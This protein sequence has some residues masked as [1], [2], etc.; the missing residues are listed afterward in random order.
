ML[1]KSKSFLLLVIALAALGADQKP[2]ELKPGFNF[3][4]KDQDIQLGREAASQV[5]KQMAIVQDRALNDYLNRL[6]H[7]L[8][9][10]PEADNYPYTFKMVVDPSINA[11]A[12]PGG[13]TFVH[14]GLITA[15]DNEA[16]LVGVMAH[17]L[18]HVALRHGTNQASK[19]NLIQIPAMLAGA[20]A[21]GGLWGQLTQLGIGLG[22]NS[23]L[24]KYSR[25][26]ER[27]AD[28]LGA[29]MM[30]HAGY[31]P[32]EMARFFE[33]L[34][35]EGGS[36]G[37]QFLSDHPN[38]GNRVKAVENEIM[39]MPR[40]DYSASTGQFQQMK[41]RIAQVA[42]STPAPKAQNQ[43]PNHQAN[44]PQVQEVRP[45][46]GVKTLSG[47]RYTLSY[48][49]NWETFGDQGSGS[50]TIAPRAGL[51]QGSGGNVSVGYGV[52]VSSSSPPSGAVD[53]NQGTQDLIRQLQQSNPGM[54]PSGNSRRSRVGGD[55]AMVT[56]LYS[57]SPYQGQREIDMLV[58]VARPQ[59][60]FYM[61]F[62]APENEFAQVQA[63]YEQMLKSVQFRD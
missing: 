4:S 58:T 25:N 16:Q 28:L 3:F 60:L 49:D 7:K 31:N 21:G 37:P 42:K 59:G 56:T 20:V 12:L 43:Q 15:A 9:S 39:M 18:S 44:P 40:S 13:P 32:I 33:K 50:V 41:Q 54:R 22:A 27:D 36:R 34:E 52:I 35:A 26:A 61:V 46:R 8:A 29:R 38:P 30:A 10:Q 19:A 23:V 57:S 5:E 11:F 55:Q 17:E 45:S 63:A 47:T 51:V 48:P 1:R 53:L 2:R 24:L 14:T 62:I 6:G